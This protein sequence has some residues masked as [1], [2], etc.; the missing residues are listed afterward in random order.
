M[1]SF[2]QTVERNQILPAQLGLGLQRTATAKNSLV[3]SLVSGLISSLDGMAV[4]QDLLSLPQIK[5]IK[6]ESN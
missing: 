1:A 6:E 5:A 3:S 4:Q 2:H